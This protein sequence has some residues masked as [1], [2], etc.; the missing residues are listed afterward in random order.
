MRMTKI[1]DPW[2]P[3]LWG[4]D[5]ALLKEEPQTALQ[6]PGTVSSPALSAVPDKG[7][8]RGNGKLPPGLGVQIML[9]LPGNIIVEGK[10]A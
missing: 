1:V 5:G 8:L 6:A 9:D 7:R 3:P 2:Q 10:Q 4:E